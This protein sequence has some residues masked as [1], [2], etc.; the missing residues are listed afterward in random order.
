MLKVSDSIAKINKTSVSTL[1][2]QPPDGANTLT[3]NKLAC[4]ISAIGLL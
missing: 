4:Q 1:K 3:P 2:K